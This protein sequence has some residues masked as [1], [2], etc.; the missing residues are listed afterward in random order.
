MDAMNS[1]YQLAMLL[2]LMIWL[3]P[4]VKIWVRFDGMPHA[5]EIFLAIL[6]IPLIML[7]DILKTFG[8]DE[9]FPH[10]IGMFRF[11]P[12]LVVIL[13]YVAIHK[14]VQQKEIPNLKLHYALAGVFFLMQ[15]PFL[16][17]HESIKIAVL[18]SAIVGDLFGNWPYY[19]F[20]ILSS[21]AIMAYGLKMEELVRNYN[22]HLAEHVADLE[23]YRLSKG[24]RVF[25]AL[26]SVSFGAI[27]LVVVVAPGLIEVNTWQS[28]IALLQFAILYISVN[29]LLHKQ[30]YA[31]APID[32][33]ELNYK[34]YNED[35]LRVIIA[36]A[37]RA[38]LVH[39]AYKHLGLRLKELTDIAHLK[40]E[41]L[42]IATKTLL[43]RDFRAYMYH[44]RIQYARKI[45]MR[46]D[47]KLA[48]IA[49]RLGFA[50]E[51]E[52]SEM[53]VK[54]MKSSPEEELERKEQM[55]NE[56]IEGEAT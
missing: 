38:V 18:N 25:S 53:F 24:T 31:P 47:I 12:V 40:P 5:R 30:R 43:N 54:Y 56:S 16:I 32:F 6:F 44:Y 10:L 49:K 50:S 2:G 4:M 1:P 9:Y 55:E 51:K 46:S 29:V 41:D 26:V 33:D 27:M 22:D 34:K 36:K 3:V 39:K 35:Q 52:L 23:F 37:E 48:T 42:I 13:V 7:D 8:L 15:I 45:I 19:L 20:Y 11:V 14:M 28:I 17:Q 21:L